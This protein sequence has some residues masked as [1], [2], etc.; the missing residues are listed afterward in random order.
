[1]GDVEIYPVISLLLDAITSNMD[2]IRSQT[3]V[4]VTQT[5]VWVT[6]HVNCSID[7]PKILKIAENGEIAA[8]FVLP[9]TL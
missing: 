3:M 6:I 7:I 1:M 8:G 2:L 9:H 5:S 4:N